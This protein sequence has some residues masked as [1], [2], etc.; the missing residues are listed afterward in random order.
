METISALLAF[1]AVT[2]EFPSQRP[3]PNNREA[4]DLSRHGAH[5]DVIIMYPSFSNSAD[6]TIIKKNLHNDASGA[7]H[8]LQIISRWRKQSMDTSLELNWRNQLGYSRSHP[9]KMLETLWKT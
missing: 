6:A 4:G 8:G 7:F 1:C 3:V 2:G 9:L 5:Y